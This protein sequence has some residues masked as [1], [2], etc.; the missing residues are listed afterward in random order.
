MLSASADKGE[1]CLF[2]TSEEG[3]VGILR[4]TH[5]CFQRASS[6][7]RKKVISRL[8]RVHDLFADCLCCIKLSS[9]ISLEDGVPRSRTC[10]CGWKSG[11]WPQQRALAPVF[12]SPFLL[13]PAPSSKS[14]TTV[15]VITMKNFSACV[16][17][18]SQ[19]CSAKSRT[20]NITSPW[21]VLFTRICDV[22]R[23]FIFTTSPRWAHLLIWILIAEPFSC[24]YCS[25]TLIHCS[26]PFPAFPIRSIKFLPFYDCL[27]DRTN[28]HSP[29]L[30][31]DE[32]VFICHHSLLPVIH[33]VTL[34]I[35]NKSKQANWPST[36]DPQGL[37][38]CQV[39]CLSIR[40]SQKILFKYNIK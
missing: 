28:R 16:Y 2:S 40:F 27:E 6:A 22:A 11:S 24:F 21:N 20:G 37:W 15:K 1:F 34:W 31:V 33:V 8:F 25:L 12:S 38:M 29:D 23:R 10:R 36:S 3:F 13:P 26:A 5:A 30:S 7:G 14:R 18:A 9:S 32:S 19:S 4:Q 39:C 35:T 17:G